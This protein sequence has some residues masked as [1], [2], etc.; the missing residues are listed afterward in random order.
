MSPDGPSSGAWRMIDAS[1]GFQPQA[2]TGSIPPSS[3]RTR[4]E[5]ASMPASYM[6]TCG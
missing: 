1:S 3:A 5:P 6:S 4:I 2:I